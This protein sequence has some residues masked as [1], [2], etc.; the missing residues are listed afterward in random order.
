MGII[1]KKESTTNKEYGCDPESRKTETLLN[2]GIINLNKPGGPT[3]HQISDYVKKILGLDKAGHGGTL[4]PKVTGV[5]PIALSRATRI[6]HFLL[7][8]GKEYVCL[9]YLHSG[10]EKEKVITAFSKFSGVIEQMPPVKSAVKRVKRKRHIYSLDILEIE[11]QNVLFRVSCQAGTY[12]R[13]LVHE[14]GQEIGCGAHMV[15]LIRTRA[16]P[17][18]LEN[19]MTLYDILDAFYLY[20]KGDESLLRKCILPIEQAVLGIK[21]IWVHD[22]AVE[23]ICHGANLNIPGISKFDSDFKEGDLVAIM[24]LKGEL[25][26]VGN[27]EIDSSEI[28]KKSNGLAV[29]SKKVFME[30]GTYPKYTK[31]T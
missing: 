13:K 23:T 30:P 31:T 3:S 24:T 26:A 1:T 17:F 27:A 11:S 15:Q 21:K 10:A 29:I 2:Y 25:I 9:M 18:K 19:S 4:D 28:I 8:S 14:I 7:K 20:K 6:V 22:S 5:L 12:I 16:G